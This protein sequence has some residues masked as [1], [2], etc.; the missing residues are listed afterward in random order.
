MTGGELVSYLARLRG[1]TD[2]R[3]VRDLA[4]RLDLDLGRPIRTL[5]KGNR[6]K[7]AVLQALMHRPELL[8][9][10]EPTSGL[11]PLVQSLVHDLLRQHARDGG[12]V[13]LSSHVLDEVQRVADRVGIIR[14]GRLVAVERLAELRAKSLHH[15][16]AA[17][18]HAVDVGEF[19]A[20][21]GVHDARV[22][23][24]TLTCRATRQALDLL[25]KTIAGHPVADLSCEEASLE[26]TFLTYYG[27][28]ESSDA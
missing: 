12:T 11:D 16:S 10:D 6:Q 19:A 23:D 17:F 7:V 15:V 21:P 18:D 25:V 22:Q 14:A 24:T 3:H 4:D 5:S 1:T 9:L 13:L 28:P 27:T 8:V 2:M 20:L 26:D